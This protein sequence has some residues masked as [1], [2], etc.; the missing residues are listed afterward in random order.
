MN[1][2]IGKTL[3]GGKYTLDQPLGQGGF[4]VTFKATHHYLNRVVVIKTLDRSNQHHPQFAKLEQQFQ[5]EARRLAKCAHPNIVRVIDFFIENGISYLVMDYIPGQTLEQVVFPDHPLPEAI[6]IL[7]IR[8][9]SAALQVV[10]QNGLLHRDVK[11]QNIIL[12]DGTQEVVLIDFGIAREFTPG[13]TQTHTSILSEGYAPVEQ[14]I[15]HAQRTPATD[16]YGLAATLYSLLTA[17]IPVASVLRNRQSMPSPRDLQPALSAAVNQSVMRGMA[18]E[19]KYR[20]QTVTEWLSLLPEPSPVSVSKPSQGAAPAPQTAATVAVAPRYPSNRSIPRRSPARPQ[21]PQRPQPT[22]DPVPQRRSD[23]QGFAILGIV[24]VTTISLTA[25]AAVWFRSQPM[26]SAPPSPSPTVTPIPTLEL[27]PESPEVDNTPSPEVVETPAEPSPEPSEEPREERRPEQRES[28]NRD[29]REER[30]R[31]RDNGELR[32][33]PGLP[34]G[35]SERKIEDL[36]GDP[37]DTADGYWRNTRSVTYE[38]IPN[39]ATLGYIYDR[40]TDRVRQTEASL[41]QSIDPLMMRVTL[42]GMLDGRMSEDIE[43]G[44]AQVRNRESDQYSFEMGDLEGVIER[45]E[46]DR[47]Y[48][49]VWEEDLH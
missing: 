47:I 2:L 29:D 7:Y 37:T 20:P 18:V 44:L 25:L 42:N 36:L 31:P 15:A 13:V 38:L 21:G 24:M 46:R 8:Q 49:G 33:I 11:P 27:P 30:D 32:S 23:L 28:R 3:Q 40:D 39:Q 6:A 1:S 10:H 35:T 16:V 41:A 4:G 34:T 48:I 45:N 43:E 26:S 17:Q 9:V 14:Y 22:P 5:D 12:R 19:A